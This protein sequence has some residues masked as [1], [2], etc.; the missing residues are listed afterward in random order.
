MWVLNLILAGIIYRG[1]IVV[2]YD[3][4]YQK[5]SYSFIKLMCK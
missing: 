3:A 1:E 5:E 4:V 2:N